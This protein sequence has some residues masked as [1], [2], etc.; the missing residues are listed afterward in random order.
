MR[1]PRS[2]SELQLEPLRGR[3]LGNKGS[4]SPQSHSHILEHL[5]TTNRENNVTNIKVPVV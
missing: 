5:H 1:S 2:H 3:F 4:L